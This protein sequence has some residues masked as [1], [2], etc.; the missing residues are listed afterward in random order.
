MNYI[1]DGSFQGLLS[2]IH[3]GVLSKESPDGVFIENK[4]NPDLF[5]CNKNVA[6]DTKKAECVIK[7]L[8]NKFGLYMM[9]NIYYAFLSNEDN[10]EK[11]IMDYVKISF[12]YGKNVD[13]FYANDSVRAVKNAFRKVAWERQK[14][15]GILRF[16]LLKDGLYYAAIEPDNNIVGLLMDH[17]KKRFS[18][19]EWLIHDISRNIGVFCK[20]GN[21]RLI[22]ID[23]FEEKLLQEGENLDKNIFDENEEKYQVLWK[24]FFKK[25]AINE[26]KNLKLQRQFLPA[27][28]WKYLP[29]KNKKDIFFKPA[30]D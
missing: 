29:E 20:D 28:Y 11:K 21:A 19:Q 24:I 16:K 5:S 14:F 8:S 27:R 23:N 22:F 2:V 9:Q 6:T 25:I 13:G 15:L 26:R 17:F 30:D 4:F 18:N 10:I 1:Y 3:E 7:I 12:E